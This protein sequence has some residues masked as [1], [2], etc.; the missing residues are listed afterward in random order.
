M[1][2]PKVLV[3]DEPS[4][5][6]APRVVAEIMRALARLRDEENLTILLIEQNARAAFTVA[7]RV[8]VM[9]RGRVLLEGAPAE[10]LNDERVQHAYL[11]GGYGAGPA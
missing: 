8:Y 6:L 10:L 4:V 7:D 3:L 1:A 9:D 2:R 5:G 11:G